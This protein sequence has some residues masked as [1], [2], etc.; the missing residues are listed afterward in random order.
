MKFIKKF[1]LWLFGRG[2]IKQSKYKY[3]PLIPLKVKVRVYE[4]VRMC[5]GGRHAWYN[6]NVGIIRKPLQL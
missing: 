5:S 1:F 2:G 6:S 4:M 3:Q